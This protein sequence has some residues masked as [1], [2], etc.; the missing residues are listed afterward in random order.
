M[1]SALGP[2]VSSRPW[3]SC[4]VPFPVSSSECHWQ[5]GQWSVD[6]RSVL[7]PYL[8]E[9]RF[10]N[11]HE[12]LPAC[13]LVP[14]RKHGILGQISS[15]PPLCCVG[16]RPQGGHS[17]LCQQSRSTRFKACRHLR[18]GSF[19]RIVSYMVK[20]IRRGVLI[21]ICQKKA[22]GENSSFGL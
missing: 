3:G 14:T 5:Q 13:Q 4:F 19:L 11:M 15:H 22:S 7:C 21:S 1:P 2:Y 18:V 17:P 9:G 8:L 16:E 6:P 20:E 12:H 10:E